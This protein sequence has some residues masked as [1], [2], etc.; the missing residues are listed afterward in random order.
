M[1]AFA[2]IN[3]ALKPMGYPCKPYLYDGKEPKYFVYNYALIQG[4][5]FGS[6]APGTT[7]ASV[8]VHLYMPVTDPKTH[9]KLNYRS[10]MLAARDALFSAGFTFPEIT[11]LREDTEDMWH[12]VFECEY[13]ETFEE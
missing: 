8:Q 13:E 5:D 4:A 10:D 9:S 1:N 7:V 3:Q 11:I 12:I 2:A 6:D